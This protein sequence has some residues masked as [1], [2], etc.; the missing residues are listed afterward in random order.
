MKKW[1]WV[2]TL[3]LLLT[4]CGTTEVMETVADTLLAPEPAHPRA[5][6]VILPGET[7]MP[8]MEGDMGR[9]YMAS[10]YEIY[11]QTMEGGDL[12]ATVETMTGFS[13]D[14]L[15]VVSTQ[16]G[17][18]QRHEFVWASAGEEGDLLGRGVVLDDGN[19]HYT[20]SVL[21]NAEKVDSSQVVWDGVFSS[22]R[23]A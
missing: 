12:S 19:F 20:M 14:D 10:D 21:R 15:T 7:A 17:D 22:F 2:V 4:G 18:A 23:L 16:Q 1:M 6:S 13:M 11:I 5:I 8:A 9:V 3:A